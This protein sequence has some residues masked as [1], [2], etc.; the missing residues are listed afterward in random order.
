MKILLDTQMIVWTAYQPE[1]VPLKAQKIIADES[2][3]MIYSPVSLWEVAIKNAQNRPSFQVDPKILRYR[4]M[5]K[6]YQELAITGFH[7]IAVSD[8]PPIHKDPF[9]RFLLAQANAEGITLLTSDAVL[10]QYPA[11]VI[12]AR[13]P[14]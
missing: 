9:D 12:L 13:K 11:P 8:L 7:A 6:K 10:A 5:E 2:N 3:T 14:L 4:L 1:L